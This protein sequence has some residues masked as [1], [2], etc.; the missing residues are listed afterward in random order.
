MFLR[1]PACRALIVCVFASV[2]ASARRGEEIHPAVSMRPLEIQTATPATNDE[3]ADADSESARAFQTTVRGVLENENF[4]QLEEIASTARSQKS[5]FSGGAWKLHTFYGVLKVPGSQTATDTEWNAHIERLQRWIAAAPDAITPRVALAETYLE[6]AW[7]ARGSGSGDSVTAEGWQLF[8]ERVQ[9]AQDTLEKAKSL[10]AK[11]TEWYRAM[12]TVCLAQEWDHAR[13]AQL[14]VDA[15]AFE[16]GYYYFYTANANYLLPKWDGAPGDSELFA[17]NIADRIGGPDGDF[18]YFQIALS[19]NC[20]KAHPQAPA[21][22]WGRVKQGFASLE[23]LYGSTSFERNAM[24]FM[25]VRQG[26]QQFAQQLFARIGDDWSERVWRRREKFEDAKTSL[27]QT[28]APPASQRESTSDLVDRMTPEQKQQFAN[29][30]NFSSQQH[31]AEAYAIYK[32]LL[33]EL[34]GDAVLSKF[35][36]EAALNSGDMAFA[37]DTLKPIAQA[38]PDDWQAAALLTRACAES[39]DK[40]CRDSGIAHMLDLHSR[41]VTP[42]NMQQYI[43]ERVKAGANTLEIWTS[44]EPWGYYKI[45]ASGRVLDAAGK[46][47]LHATLE[48]NDADQ[49]FFA[50]QHPAEAA[51]GLREFSLDGY[52]ETGLNANGQR[53]QTHFTYA[54]F[55]GQPS[56][57]TV[58]NDFIA[59]GNGKATPMSSRTGL[60]VP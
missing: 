42:A 19:L 46:L 2:S 8:G 12:Q 34:P 9:Q 43:V 47:F 10:S 59:I 11:D 16:P 53:T 60:I 26:D 36:S 50:Q 56:Y 7:K 22:S 6:F 15:N 39:G 18:V 54:F 55:V 24:A 44:I 21:L 13:A 31:D 17:K 4:A 30:G 23:Q 32:Q 29:A 25:A 57:E 45:Y 58:R 28:V 40:S 33:S 1:T 5:R 51:K 20:C 3:D 52:L 48:S 41:G 35:A 49:P 37:L 14:L 38:D 27:I